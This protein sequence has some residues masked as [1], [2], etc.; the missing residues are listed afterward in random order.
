[1]T[2]GGNYDTAAAACA[3]APFRAFES[4]YATHIQNSLLSQ[5]NNAWIPGWTANVMGDVRVPVKD[6]EWTWM[7]VDVGQD[8]GC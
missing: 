5:Y 8:C 4:V 2:C 3:A 1:M 7:Q 6:S